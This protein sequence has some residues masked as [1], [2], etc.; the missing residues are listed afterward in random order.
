[1]KHMKGCDIT[2]KSFEII[3]EGLRNIDV[4]P[5]QLEIIIRI[6]HTTGDIDFAKTFLFTSD[7]VENGITALRM[8]GNVITDVEMART[9]IRKSILQDL[10]GEALCFLSHDD[11]I[12]K[13]KTADSTRSALGMRKAAEAMHKGIVAIGNAP[14]ALFELIEMIEEG[15]ASPALIVGVPVGFVGAYESKEALSKSSIPHITNF[16][17]RGGSTIAAAIVNGFIDLAAGR[18]PTH[19]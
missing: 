10:G 5:D 17:T 13:S 2:K 11:V 8:G 1:M 16:H 12:A 6:A 3:R 9:G 4:S 18:D 19:G 14:T 7:A 15:T